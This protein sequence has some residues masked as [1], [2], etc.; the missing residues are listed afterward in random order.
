MAL[1]ELD[2]QLIDRCT[3]RE[4]GA[5]NDF[6]DR[7]IGLFIH[8]VELTAHRRSVSLQR[9]DR[10]DLVGDIFAEIIDDDFGVLRRFDKRSSLATYLTVVARRVATREI[11]RRRRDEG[12]GL[13]EAL[14]A[15]AEQRVEDHDLIA[16]LIGRLPSHEAAI[17]RMF[18]IEGR[19]YREI[20][21]LQGVP[22]SS[23]GATLARARKKME[24]IGQLRVVGGGES[25]RRTG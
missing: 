16:N 22:E 20:A 5:W 11:V 18:H 14:A 12:L 1:T 4:T 15:E 24:Q 6:V 23:I 13:T 8:V 25:G 21:G 19:S 2:R 9:A 3:R 10:D 7:Y 17:V